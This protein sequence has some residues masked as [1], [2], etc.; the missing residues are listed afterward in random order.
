MLHNH[1][2]N[3]RR[4]AEGRVPVNTLWFWG[5]G[6]HPDRVQAPWRAVIGA[7]DELAALAA[8]AGIGAGAADSG[9][10]LLDLR[11]ER[12]GDAIASTVREAFG[13]LAHRHAE[14]VL[15]FADGQAL[16]VTRRQRW[17]LLRPPLR[18]WDS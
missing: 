12:D 2:L 14:V 3:A 7:D 16:R 6:R 8:A 4:A 18:R 17:R 15:D 9:D 1:P 11:R 13:S 5:G 10:V